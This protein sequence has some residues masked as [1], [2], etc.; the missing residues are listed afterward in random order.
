[1]Q[2][3]LS[4]ALELCPGLQ[5]HVSCTQTLTTT[6]GSSYH[7]VRLALEMEGSPFRYRSCTQLNQG[8]QRTSHK[9]KHLPEMKV[10]RCEHKRH[11]SWHH[12]SERDTPV[13]H[14]C[15]FTCVLCRDRLGGLHLHRRA[16]SQSFPKAE[17]PPCKPEPKDAPL[18]AQTVP[19]FYYTI[20][21]MLCYIL[22]YFII[23]YYTIL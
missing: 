10:G 8:Q 9:M 7:V 21:I 18:T 16:R 4:K 19:N 3:S 15:A 5:L 2:K 20:F 6:S 17:N 22:F 11:N 12:A 23:I 13:S 14:C 1:M